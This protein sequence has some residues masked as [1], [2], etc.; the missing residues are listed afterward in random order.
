L[1]LS[2]GVVLGLAGCGKTTGSV[3]SAA[4]AGEKASTTSTTTGPKWQAVAGGQNGE[5]SFVQRALA[6]NS[7]ALTYH[8][9]GS[10]ALADQMLSKLQTLKLPVTVFAIGQWLEQNKGLAQ[11]ILAGG[12]E[13]ANHT[14]THPDFNSLS[15]SAMVTEIQ[16][17]RDVLVGQTGSPGK[18]FRPSSEDAVPPAAVLT[19]SQTAGYPVVVG[20]DVDPVDYDEPGA[21]TVVSRVASKISGGSIVSLHFGHA[22]T[23]EAMDGIA[24]TLASKGLTPVTVSQL[25]G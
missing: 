21:A 24:Q 7:V 13:L 8:G 19:A 15:P 11:D 12:H 22:G 10:R 2:A 5:A 18:W 14:Y 16:K 20:F 9:G 6:G 25:L 4:A 23:I 3:S 1:T 17:C